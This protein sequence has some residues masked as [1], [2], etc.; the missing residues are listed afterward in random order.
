MRLVIDACLSYTS[1]NEAEQKDIILKPSSKGAMFIA[2]RK[3][4]RNAS[5]YLGSVITDQVQLIESMLPFLVPKRAWYDFGMGD[6]NE[7]TP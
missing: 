3:L 4:C 6:C 7:A 2:N 1:L 5:F